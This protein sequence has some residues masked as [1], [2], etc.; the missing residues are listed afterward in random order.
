MYTKQKRRS[1]YTKQKKKFLLSPPQDRTFKHEAILST[2]SGYSNIHLLSL[3][4]GISNTKD[5]FG[6]TITY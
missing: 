4:K 1:M 2:L 5:K 3:R 6:N